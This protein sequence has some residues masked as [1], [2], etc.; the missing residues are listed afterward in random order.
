MAI[1]YRAYAI[2]SDD[3]I[4]LRVDLMCDDDEDANERAR[5]LVDYHTIELWQGKQLLARFEP[6]R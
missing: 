3:R 2:G 6:V 4:I 1:E 5:Q